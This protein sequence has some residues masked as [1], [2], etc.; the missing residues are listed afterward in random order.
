MRRLLPHHLLFLWLRTHL[1]LV[2]PVCHATRRVEVVCGDFSAIETAMEMESNGVGRVF[3]VRLQHPAMHSDTI[4]LVEG[5]KYEGE[6]RSSDTIDLVEGM[7]YEGE[8]KSFAQQI[9]WKG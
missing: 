6:L 4:D 1:L 9:W 8:L 5:M 7:K 3:D 2:L